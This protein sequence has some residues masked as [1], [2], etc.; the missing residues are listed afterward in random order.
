[1]VPHAATFCIR[2]GIENVTGPAL[3]IANVVVG[4]T[5]IL[6]MT[7][8]DRSLSGVGLVST[9]PM[10]PAS[11]NRLPNRVYRKNFRAASRFPPPTPQLPIRKNVGIR[12]SSKN[13]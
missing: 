13:T 5:S 12:V 7:R 10:R 11:V 8:L 9:M 4:S 2:T 6:C 3:G 1:M